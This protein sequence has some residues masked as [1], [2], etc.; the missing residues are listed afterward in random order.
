LIRYAATEISDPGQPLQFNQSTRREF[1][2]VVGGAAAWPLVARA[3]QPA[4]PVIGFLSSRRPTESSK[5]VAAFRQG[6]ATLGYVETQNVA[7]EYRWAHDQYDRLPVLAAELVRRPVALLMSSGG[8]VTALTA[9]AATATIP[10]V[11]VTG[12]DPVALHLVESLNRPGGNVTG[13]SF[14]GTQLDPK[15][16]ELLAE[17]TPKTADLGVLINPNNPNSDGKLKDVRAAAGAVGRR[18]I[19]ARAG[20][21]HNL[22]PAF[23]ALSEQRAGGVLID[24]DPFLS[25]RRAQIAILAVRQGL[26]TINWGREYA[27]AGGLMSYGASY[28]DNHRQAGEYAAKIL[29][30][31]KPAD[32]PI[33]Q[34]VKFELVINLNSARALGLEVPPTLLA[35]ADEVI[36]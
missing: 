8:S 5:F 33:L 14:L 2:A 17:V 23:R 10:I 20:A 24:A 4:M 11:F 28:A 9:K 31:A 32:L 29:K 7:I 27:E 25:S 12:A 15:L 36:E 18:L 19:V 30:G 3:Q 1:I 21:E 6:L 13:V 26:P 16:L 34:P 22:E 35:R